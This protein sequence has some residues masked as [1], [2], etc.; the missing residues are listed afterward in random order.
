MRT[1]NCYPSY[2]LCPAFDFIGPLDS[3]WSLLFQTEKFYLF[4]STPF[5]SCSVTLPLVIL[6]VISSSSLLLSD[7]GSSTSAQA[8][9]AIWDV[10]KQYSD[11]F[12][13]PSFSPPMPPCCLS[14]NNYHWTLSWCY[15]AVCNNS[16]SV[17]TVVVIASSEPIA[18]D[19]DWRLFFHMCI[20]WCLLEL[21]FICRLFTLSPWRPFVAL[22][23]FKGL[24]WFTPSLLPPFT[25]VGWAT[26]ALAQIPQRLQL[27][28]T[29]VQA[30]CLL[31]SHLSF[32]NQFSSKDLPSCSM[33]A[34]FNSLWWEGV[35]KGFWKS[36]WT[37]IPCACHR[38]TT[39][40]LPFVTKQ[41]SWSN[42]LV[43]ITHLWTVPPYT[44]H[45][46]MSLPS[47]FN[48][49]QLGWNKSLL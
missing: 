36:M 44:F 43:Y 7:E 40:L 33:T 37:G 22:F 18:L 9:S 46:G 47:S 14:F 4:N 17:S 35:S 32:C 5:G 34:S 28:P 39:Q 16:W 30:G 42:F 29:I 24:G 49:A 3:P 21:N 6:W 2:L 41:P 23:W 31:L 1:S 12:L 27:S 48:N 26:Q 20:T 11:V 45:A 19:L 38:K 25:S 15:R 13:L 8:V 10:M